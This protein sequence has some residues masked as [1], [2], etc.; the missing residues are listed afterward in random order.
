MKPDKRLMFAL[1]ILIYC[2]MWFGHPPT[3]SYTIDPSSFEQESGFMKIYSCG[4][5]YIF[6]IEIE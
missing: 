4:E 3:A 1:I 5:D 6:K 2:L